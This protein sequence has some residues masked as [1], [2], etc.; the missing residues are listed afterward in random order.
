M[1][2]KWEEP[3]IIRKSGIILRFRGSF[4]QQ[5]TK[6]S[7]PPHDTNEHFRRKKQANGA[8]TSER[9]RFFE[10]RFALI[11]G[12]NFKEKIT[13]FLNSAATN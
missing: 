11:S 5:V 7:T 2:L 12:L 6:G 10:N 4:R 3:T 1:K 13:G 8:Y 9:S